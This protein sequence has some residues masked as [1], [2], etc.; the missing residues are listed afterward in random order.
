MSRT[1]IKTGIRAI[2]LTLVAV[3]ALGGCALP[4]KSILIL[5]NGHGTGC[6]FTLTNWSGRDKCELSL[7]EGDVL[8]VEI[9]RDDGEIGLIIQ[10]ANGTEP[11]VGNDLDEGT[12]T[13]TIHES[14]N[15]IV[16]VRGKKATGSVT[17]EKAEP[18][19]YEE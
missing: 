17:V 11:Y 16:G 8:S 9:D 18:I 14:G 15:Y 13:V 2:L 12:F 6:S 1:T 10:G 4:D 5:E 19:P 3:V 7:L